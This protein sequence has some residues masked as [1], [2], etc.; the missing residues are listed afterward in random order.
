MEVSKNTIDYLPYDPND[1]ESVLDYLNNTHPDDIFLDLT[2]SQ[3]RDLI[4]HPDER[5]R[6]AYYAVSYNWAQSIIKPSVK[7]AIQRRR[8]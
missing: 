7:T 1:A 3:L 4:V 5:V 8:N 6:D 2:P